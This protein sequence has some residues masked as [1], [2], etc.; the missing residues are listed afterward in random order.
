MESD[1]L[2]IRRQTCDLIR[3]AFGIVDASGR[4]PDHGM[5][6]V[7]AQK[8]RERGFDKGLVVAFGEYIAPGV[9][10]PRM[11]AMEIV[12][13]LNGGFPVSYDT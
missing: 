6:H 11:T 5:A 9:G 8:A 10:Y 4:C 7:V 1:T 12:A 2:E 3:T 13:H